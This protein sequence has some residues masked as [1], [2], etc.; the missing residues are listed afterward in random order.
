MAR[1]LGVGGVFVRAKDPA[2][3]K[4]WY[5]DALG[6]DFNLGSAVSFVAREGAD[7]V[8]FSLFEPDSAYIGDPATQG[9]MVNFVV[10]DLEGVLERL[11]ESGATVEPIQDEGYGRFSW[12][13]DPEG[14]RVELW[15][16]SGS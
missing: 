3:L 15:E 14:N 12:T 11:S 7:V 2:V 8:V 6:I 16:P 13:T 4:A 10:D 5:A 9:A 1:V